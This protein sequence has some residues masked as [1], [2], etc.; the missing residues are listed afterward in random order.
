MPAPRGGRLGTGVQRTLAR[1]TGVGVAVLLSQPSTAWAQ[2][3][4][5]DFTIALS[6]TGTVTVGQPAIYTIVVS[7]IGGTAGGGALQVGTDLLGDATGTGWGCSHLF[8]G[9]LKCFSGVVI[10][11]G[12]SAPPITVMARHLVSGTVTNEADVSG[13]GPTVYDIATDVTIVLPAV[14]TLPEWAMIVLSALLAVAGV[15]AMRRRTTGPP[16]TR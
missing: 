1:L 15:A 3:V 12:G 4:G 5:P 10:A 9:E 7:N 8:H 14:P 16:T 11:P 2:A 6:H 13:G